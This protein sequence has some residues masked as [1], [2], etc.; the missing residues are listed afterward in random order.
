MPA[1]TQL[2][3]QQIARGGITPSLTAANTDGQYFDNNGRCFLEVVNAG[4]DTLTLSIETPGV[5]DS[6]AIADREVAVVA[7][8]GNKMIGPFPTNI[9]NDASGRVN[10][11]YSAV[12]DV[13]VGVFRL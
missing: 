9:Y 3:V 5:V 11:S 2:T 1:P 4:G 10:V 6:L 8:T 12:T 7:T 13:T